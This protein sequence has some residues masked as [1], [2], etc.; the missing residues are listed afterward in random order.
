MCYLSCRYLSESCNEDAVCDIQLTSNVLA[1]TQNAAP[2][3]N[4][5]RIFNSAMAFTTV[6]TVLMNHLNVAVSND[7]SH[8]VNTCVA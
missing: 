8:N 2:T 5:W 6:P 1:D 4:V 3:R 7:A